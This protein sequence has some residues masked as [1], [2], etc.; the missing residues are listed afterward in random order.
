MRN[1]ILFAIIIAALSATSLKAQSPA[2]GVVDVQTIVEQMPD[3]IK[4][5]KELK[6]LGQAYQ[7]SLIK[8]QQDFEARLKKYESQKAMMSPEQQTKEEESLKAYQMQILQ[9]RE[10][11]FGQQGEIAQKRDQYLNP[12]RE[13]VQAAIDAVA[14]EE[15]MSFVFDKSS[16]MVLY[17][18]DKYDITFKVLDKIKR[19]GEK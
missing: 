10:Q 4:A 17:S 16:E 14:K 13:K 3:A 1:F 12:I 9:F 18:L 8:Y 2:I 15:K 11:K 19:G 6:A 7:D 5:D